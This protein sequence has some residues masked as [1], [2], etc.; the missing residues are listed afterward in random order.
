MHQDMVYNF[1][2]NTTPLAHT[3]RCANQGMYSTQHRF[4]TVQGHPEFNRDMVTKILTARRDAHVISDEMYQDGIKRVGDTHGGAVIA[5]A[6]LR[7]LLLS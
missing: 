1:P 6:F 3:P 2:P 7:F 5:R 4:L